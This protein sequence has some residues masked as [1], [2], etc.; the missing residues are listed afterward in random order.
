MNNISEDYLFMFLKVRNHYIANALAMDVI[1]TLQSNY[2]TYNTELDAFMLELANSTADT[3]GYA[4][5]K[6]SKR[7]DLTQRALQISNSLT[8]YYTSIDDKA[9]R[10]LADYPTSYFTNASAEDLSARCLALHNLADSVGALLVPFGVTVLQIAEFKTA[11]DEYV[12]INPE[13]SL[14]IDNRKQAAA[15]AEKIRLRIMDLLVNKID[16]LVRVFE[17]SN[18]FLYNT[19]LDARALDVTGT[20][21]TPDYVGT[22]APMVITMVVEIPYVAGRSFKIKNAGDDFMHACL[23]NN[24][25]E[26]QGTI[27]VVQGGNTNTWLSSTFNPDSSANFLLL[28]NNSPLPQNYEVTI[29]E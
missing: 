14:A 19:Y 18:S 4:M 22:L 2:T 11:L 21:T 12:A 3:T 7:I 20:P 6:E 23:S 9:G 27:M 25:A 16:V 1:P 15:K 8:A 13:G 28:Q 10:K 26:I 29:V 24:P 17:L 5:D